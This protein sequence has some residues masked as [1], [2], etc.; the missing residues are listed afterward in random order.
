MI[1]IEHLQFMYLSYH[2]HIIIIA[3]LKNMGRTI[4]VENFKHAIF[5][6]TFIISPILL[7]LYE[8][9]IT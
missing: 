3:Y 5:L 8:R 6:K 7:T 9:Y 1:F 4:Y 2:Y